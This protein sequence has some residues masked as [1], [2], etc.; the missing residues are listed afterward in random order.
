VLLQ[1]FADFPAVV[2]RRIDAEAH[3]DSAWHAIGRALAAQRVAV[4]TRIWTAIELIDFGRTAILFDG[5][6]IGRGIRKCTL[7]MSPKRSSTGWGCGP[8]MS[9]MSG[10]G[11]AT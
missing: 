7:A 3:A 5:T 11:S 4:P 10:N 6:D 9:A 2:A 8:S 1:A